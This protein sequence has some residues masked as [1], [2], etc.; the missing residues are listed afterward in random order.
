MLRST[1]LAAL[2]LAA[3]A[4][5]ATIEL[6]AGPL[7]LAAGQIVRVV[8]TDS[9]TFA[10]RASLTFLSGPVLADGTVALI[11]VPMPLGDGDLR[12]GV[13]LV[14]VHDPNIRPVLEYAQVVCDCR[15]AG[16][17]GCGNERR[18]PPP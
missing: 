13:G 6:R 18:A 14:G 17:Y 7:S 2:A 3:P 8:V 15:G 9:A 1:L 10:C 11:R 4:H 16:A 12:G 5:A